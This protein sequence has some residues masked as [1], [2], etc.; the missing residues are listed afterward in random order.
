M[1]DDS[2]TSEGVA[3]DGPGS[4]E[5]RLN[6]SAEARSG[7]TSPASGNEPSGRIDM[8]NVNDDST[9]VVRSYIKGEYVRRLPLELRKDNRK[10]RGVSKIVGIEARTR[11]YGV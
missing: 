10:K 11:R 5:V 6:A 3:E 8:L 1:S 2:A 7:D 4:S 9:R